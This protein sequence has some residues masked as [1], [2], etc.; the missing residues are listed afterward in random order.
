MRGISAEACND[1]TA[2]LFTA[3][4]LVCP[5]SIER[6]RYSGIVVWC[7]LNIIDAK[8]SAAHNGNCWF[9]EWEGAQ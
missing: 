4:K 1:Q 2:T 6:C 8:L 9:Q 3:F 7:R 5:L